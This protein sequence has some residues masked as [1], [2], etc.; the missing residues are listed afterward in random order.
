MAKA[1][2]NLIVR[3]DMI[4]CKYCGRDVGHA[5]IYTVPVCP[6]CKKK[7]FIRHG[8]TPMLIKDEAYGS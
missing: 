3:P 7:E 5:N 2:I 4:T 8:N 1:R 6:S